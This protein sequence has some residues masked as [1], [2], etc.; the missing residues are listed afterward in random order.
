MGT[1]SFWSE[2]H[3]TQ[4][5]GKAI[6]GGEVIRPDVHEPSG[7]TVR[8]KWGRCISAL[9]EVVSKDIDDLKGSEKLCGLKCYGFNE[10]TVLYKRA[11]VGSQKGP[12]WTAMLRWG[13]S[14]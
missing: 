3:R 14:S 11:Q 12:R 4:C 8:R 1:M 13:F 7:L 2:D 9:I 5:G 10:P 6:Q